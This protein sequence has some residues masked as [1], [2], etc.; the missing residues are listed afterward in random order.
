MVNRDLLQ[1][2]SRNN[3]EFPGHKKTGEWLNTPIKQ[4]SSG[5]KMRLAFSTAVHLNY[6]ILLLDEIFTVGDVHFQEKCKERM[7]EVAVDGKTILFASHNFEP[8]K[9][10]CTRILYLKEG[11]LAADGSPE[12]IIELYN[13]S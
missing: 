9:K 12:E 13:R 6:N 7:E 1:F 2:L 8:L 5:M 3:L 11:E 4:Y 10:F